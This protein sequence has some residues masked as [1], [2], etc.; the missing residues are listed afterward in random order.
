MVKFDAFASGIEF[1]GLRSMLDIKILVCYILDSVKLPMTRAQICDTF[2]ETGLANYFDA[3]S[4]IDELLQTKAILEKEYVGEPHLYVSG[5]GVN[6]VAE[7][8]KQL[9]PGVRERAVKAAIKIA[10]RAQSERETAVHIEK[11][12]EGCNV[13]FEVLS[14]GFVMMSLTLAVADNLQAEQLKEG[15]LDNPAALYSDVIDRLIGDK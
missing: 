8:E 7:L 11:T 5:I 1:G 13:T 9:L 14:G 12:D 6:S 15:F 3:N 10:S 2:Q 4:A